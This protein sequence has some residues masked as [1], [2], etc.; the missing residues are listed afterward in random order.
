MAIDNP[1]RCYK[2]HYPVR[3]FDL[4]GYFLL[5]WQ[6]GSLVR[7]DLQL[8]AIIIKFAVRLE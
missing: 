1:K 5:W 4:I 7:V 3:S 2:T 6:N 8:I